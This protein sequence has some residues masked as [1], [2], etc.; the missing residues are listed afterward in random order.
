MSYRY[1]HIFIGPEG[2]ENIATTRSYEYPTPESAAL[3]AEQNQPPERETRWNSSALNGIERFADWR[4]GV[5][6]AIDYLCAVVVHPKE[7]P[8]H[9]V[10]RIWWQLMVAAQSQA[11]RDLYQRRTAFADRVRASAAPTPTPTYL[12]RDGSMA[13]INSRR[14]A[15]GQEPYTTEAWQQ[16]WDDAHS[17]DVKAKRHEAYEA[18]QAR[19]EELP[20][21]TD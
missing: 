4:L 6:S 8:T 14:T 10:E 19:L 13:L 9:V 17:P 12:D 18:E 21:L 1:T 5:T 16:L 15:N 2:A 11:N 7:V 20:P 3:A